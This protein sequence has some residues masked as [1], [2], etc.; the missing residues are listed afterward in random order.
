[1]RNLRGSLAA[2]S[3]TLVIAATATAGP[4]WVEGGEGGDDAG[5]LPNSAQATVGEGELMFI[6]GGLDGL[7]GAAGVPDLHDMY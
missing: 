7:A 2:V 6:I 4:A 1:M 3:V 5:A